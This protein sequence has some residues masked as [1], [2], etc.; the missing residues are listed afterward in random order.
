[1]YVSNRVT[2]QN[3]TFPETVMIVMMIKENKITQTL[4]GRNNID[5][6]ASNQNKEQNKTHHQEATKK[7][8]LTHQWSGGEEAQLIHL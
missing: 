8:S 2:E 7:H 1:M 5:L 3:Q 6:S 4:T